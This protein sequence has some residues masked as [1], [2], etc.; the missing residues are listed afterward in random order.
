M[1]EWTRAHVWAE[2]DAAHVWR[3]RIQ[4][5][6]T[7][8]VLILAWSAILLVGYAVEAT[9]HAPL[10]HVDTS[11]RTECANDGDCVLFVERVTC[12]GDCPPVPPFE[13]VP[14]TLLD[15]LRQELD[16]RCAPREHFCDPPE[17]PATPSGCEAR[18]V[19]RAGT[20]SVATNGRCS[21]G[22]R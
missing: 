13:A 4:V 5:F 8:A 7:C 16:D 10:A 14:R 20:C 11:E 9:R 6:T 18:A 19:C 21:E 17:C 3:T 15:E 12:C 2:H 22:G 1:K